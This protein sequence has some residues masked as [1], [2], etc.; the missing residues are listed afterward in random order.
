MDDEGGIGGLLRTYDCMVCSG[1]QP[2]NGPHFDMRAEKGFENRAG[3][4][5]GVAKEWKKGKP[6]W[7]P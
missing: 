7:K 3:R 2:L 5:L 4:R 6:V 1:W